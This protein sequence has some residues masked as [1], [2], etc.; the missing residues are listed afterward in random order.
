MTRRRIIHVAVLIA[1]SVATVLLYFPKYDPTVQ[2][3]GEVGYESLS[4]ADSLV[5]GQGFANP[6]PVPTGPS[7]H[8][9]PL[10]PAMI[11]F[12][13]AHTL[14]APSADYVLQWLAVIAMTIELCLMP[15][16]AEHMG[17]GFF[18]GVVGSV[19]WLLARIQLETVWEQTFA[20]VL[21]TAISFLMYDG[22]RKQ[23]VWPRLLLCAGLWGVSLLLSP[24][25]LLPWI[26]WLCLIYLRREQRLKQK[27]ALTL[28]PFLIVAPWIV[29]NYRVFH[30]LFFVRDNL[31][32]ELRVGNNSCASFSFEI[33]VFT[34]CY[35]QF[36]PND[37]PEE[38][39]RMAAV[40]E[41]AYDQEQMRITKAWI[42]S[43]PRQFAKLTGKRI[44]AFWMPAFLRSEQ[45]VLTDDYEYSPKRDLFV[46]AL[47]L[48]TFCGLFVLWRKN[49][50]A[51]LIFIVWLVAYP[52]IYYVVQ[53]NER[54][55]LP[56]L[57]A[58]TLPGCYSVI[59]V[60][61]AIWERTRRPAAP[62]LT[63]DQ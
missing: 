59:T 63:T 24:V 40:G 6:F 56:V 62:S 35:T 17:M 60:A 14:D 51:F 7:A 49:R 1:I 11:A 42:T 55:R 10:F 47:S 27:L 26:A 61:T 45:K 38:N 28:L 9:A 21:I 13:G 37:N 34:D 29:R 44:V 33:N 50:D 46:S 36:H 18:A 52:G 22:L 43:S 23:F 30:H 2:P 53:Y 4:I 16:L 15:L 12:V 41:Y 54:Y 20:A 39:Q 25:T 31:G 57:W 19:V 8:L 3:F 32:L 5:K 48:A 58:M